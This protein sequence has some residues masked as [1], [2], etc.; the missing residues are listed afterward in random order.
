VGLE[1]P[2]PL[3]IPWSPIRASPNLKCTNYDVEGASILQQFSSVL[4][5]LFSGSIPAKEDRV[6]VAQAA[7]V[8]AL[9]C[10]ADADREVALAQQ[11]RYAMS[12][13]KEA[14]KGAAVAAA[15]GPKGD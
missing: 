14:H 10:V 6:S 2:L 5:K 4:P 8:A 9:A 1:P 11:E 15:M 3:R 12:G 7:C 13:P